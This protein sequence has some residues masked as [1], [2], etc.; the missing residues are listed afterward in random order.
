VNE[1]SG[2][3]QDS[4]SALRGEVA[5]TWEDMTNYGEGKNLYEILAHKM[6]QKCD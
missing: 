4:T 1:D 3:V 6:K 2:S 5:F